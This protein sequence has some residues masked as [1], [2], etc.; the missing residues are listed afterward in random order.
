[1]Q[2]LIVWPNL[3]QNVNKCTFGLGKVIKLDYL[4]TGINV[5][6]SLYNERLLTD[7]NVKNCNFRW[8]K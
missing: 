7:L 1:M 2:L 4:L 3:E 5:E 6:L 8:K